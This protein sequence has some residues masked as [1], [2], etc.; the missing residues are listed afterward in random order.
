MYRG[1]PDG[2]QNV[3]SA[4]C[5]T[6]RTEREQKC[7]EEFRNELRHGTEPSAHRV[8]RLIHQRGDRAHTDQRTARAEH[9]ADTEH[10]RTD[11]GHLADTVLT[12][13]SGFFQFEEELASVGVGI[14][15]KRD[16]GD[17][18]RH[19]H[20]PKDRHDDTALGKHITFRYLV[21]Y[22]TA[23]Q[24]YAEHD[25]GD[26]GGKNDVNGIDHVVIG[27]E[28]GRETDGATLQLIR[29]FGGIALPHTD[30]GDQH[31]NERKKSARLRGKRNGKANSQS[32]EQARVKL[33]G[34]YAA[35][36]RA[37]SIHLPLLLLH[38][39]LMTAILAIQRPVLQG[40]MALSTIH[41]IR[42]LF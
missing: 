7:G 10:P 14:S 26:D 17:D 23:Y 1:H 8:E 27:I 16:D 2:R 9:R 25:D 31:E 28:N 39:V 3:V 5:H 22:L 34:K 38:G 41:K 13:L 30:H 11:K 40:L 42:S 6:Y 18:D 35:G 36:L 19:D 24:R 15:A 12:R 29:R 33:G 32:E 37:D 4:R 20:K 21:Q